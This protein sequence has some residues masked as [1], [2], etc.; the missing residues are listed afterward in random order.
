VQITT[1]ASLGVRDRISPNSTGGTRDAGAAADP[2]STG[3][4]HTL[5]D[6]LTGRLPETRGDSLRLLRHK[7]EFD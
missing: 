3:V 4:I 6:T 1:S 2:P 5:F 7:S